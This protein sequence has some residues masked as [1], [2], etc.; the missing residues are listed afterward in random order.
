MQSL[1]LLSELRG[2]YKS[3]LKSK[4][5]T[6]G[7]NITLQLPLS[8]FHSFCTDAQIRADNA[9]LWTQTGR[10]GV[11]LMSML[12]GTHT[13]PH[14]HIGRLVG[15]FVMGTS[16]WVCYHL[17]LWL[18]DRKQG[19]KLHISVSPILSAEQKS[20][21]LMSLCET[22][23]FTFLWSKEQVIAGTRAHTH[24]LKPVLSDEMFVMEEC[25]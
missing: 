9:F 5:A 17:S 8:P 25:V 7:L 3:W 21:F 20:C 15:R 16:P 24:T 2:K 14:T 23:P 13:H 22:K 18:S 19:S 10:R 1:S 6:G 12:T 4:E 11:W